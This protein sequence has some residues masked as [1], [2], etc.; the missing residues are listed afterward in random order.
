MANTNKAML[1]TF[2]PPAA[3]SVVINVIVIDES[4]N[5]WDG[6]QLISLGNSNVGIGWIWNGENFSPPAENQ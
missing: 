1:E 6:K 5:E 3:E 4:I 2:V